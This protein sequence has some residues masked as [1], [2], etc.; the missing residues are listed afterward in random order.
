MAAITWYEL[1]WLARRGRISVSLPIGT[2]LGR[3]A[4]SVRT[5]A[6]SP[7]I[8]ATA[9]SLPHT[10]PSDPA[11]RLIYAT[12]VEQG[13]K[14]VTKDDRLRLHRGAPSATTIW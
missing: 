5:V 1:A 6:L 12:A 10:F 7:S 13:W 3:L 2:W 14:L 11:D 4:R 9:V 8:A